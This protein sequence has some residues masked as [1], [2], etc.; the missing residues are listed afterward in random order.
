MIRRNAEAGN[1]SVA[2]TAKLAHN[3]GV[4]IP[5]GPLREQRRGLSLRCLPRPAM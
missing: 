3:D 5:G 2:S 4:K 1:F